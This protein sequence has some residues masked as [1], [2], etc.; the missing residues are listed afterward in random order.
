MKKVLASCFVVALVL[1]FGVGSVLA[2]DRKRDRKRDGTC[3][4]FQTAESADLSLAA[5]KQRDRKRD[6]TCR[7]LVRADKDDFLNL[8]ADRKRDRKR[9]GTCRS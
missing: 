4:S 3:R 7:N 5:A 6:G 9:D 1:I 2:A 8:A